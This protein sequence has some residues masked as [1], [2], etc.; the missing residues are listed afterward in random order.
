[1]SRK[2]KTRS[3]WMASL[4]LVVSEQCSSCALA[5]IQFEPRGRSTTSGPLARAR[6]NQEQPVTGQPPKRVCMC[7][8]PESRTIVRLALLTHS[9]HYGGG[10]LHK[11]ATGVCVCVCECT[12]VWSSRCLSLS[13]VVLVF[14]RSRAY[15]VSLGCVRLESVHRWRHTSLAPRLA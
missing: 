5:R 12:C 11:R 9:L 1:M 10:Q 4:E 15:Y 13:F 3:S 8:S 14:R 2:R 6:N 7:D